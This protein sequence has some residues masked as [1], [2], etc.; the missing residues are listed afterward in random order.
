M[1]SRAILRKPRKL[2]LK[3]KSISTK[4]FSSRIEIDRWI[5]K[6]YKISRTKTSH[7]AAGR[8]NETEKY[9]KLVSIFLLDARKAEIN[10]I[11]D[12]HGLVNA[13]RFLIGP[14]KVLFSFGPGEVKDTLSNRVIEIIFVR[15]SFMGFTS[16]WFVEIWKFVF[17]GKH[18]NTKKRRRENLDQADH[19]NCGWDGQRESQLAVADSKGKLFAVEACKWSIC[20]IELAFA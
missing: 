14:E 20:S 11:G 4:T 3:A 5:E 18:F 2:F 16:G 19:E 9:E 6:N 15:D 1:P 10:L 12:S 13:A 7:W 17:Y 8:K